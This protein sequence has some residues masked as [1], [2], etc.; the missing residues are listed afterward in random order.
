MLT[1]LFRLIWN[2]K[3][4][5]FLLMLEIF[6]SFI[7]M[8]AVFTFVLY[9]YNSY[10]L[11]VGIKDENVWAVYFNP[12]QGIKNTD[13]LQ[14]FRE[15]VKKVLLATNHVEDVIYSS[16]NLPFSDNTSTTGIAF[17]GK[18]TT[19]NAYTVEDNYL[20]I[21][22]LKVLEGRW[23]SKEDDVSKYKPAVIN[24]AL[25]K[26]L[27]GTG[28]AVG[29]V[30]ESGTADKMKVVGVLANF[31]DKSEFQ[32]PESGLFR[33][34]DTSEIR[35]HNSMLIKVKQGA[36]AAFEGSVSKILT[37]TIKSAD[38]NRAIENDDVH[39]NVEI[40]SLT[41]LKA[42]SNKV[43][44][45]P[46]I[47]FV[48]VAGFLIINVALGIFGVLWYNINKR[49]GEIGLRRA[50]GATGKAISWQ[51]VAEAILLA[52]LSLMLGLFFAVQFPLLNVFDLS[53]NIYITAI[54]YAILF[55]YALVI[56]C[57]LY[58]GR[59]AAAIY[60]TEALHED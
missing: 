27:F 32:P 56:L 58:P 17:D 53:A 36:D 29:K 20:N 37:N 42:T 14:T 52:T 6:F 57:A 48:I 23:F 11:P 3:K 47:V 15:S 31:K 44:F 46:L 54:I 1:H 9:H 4:Q 22:G 38:V 10:K 55:I 7:C 59:Q 34:M 51:L 8:F 45:V 33:R 16:G 43:T 50:V 25:K 26:E 19:V 35:Y 40:D 21:L 18:K 41:D 12:P 49:K 60:P 24:E 30:I 39:D 28:A 5:N 13:S 2:K